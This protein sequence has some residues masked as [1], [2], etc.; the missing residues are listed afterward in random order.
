MPDLAWWL[1]NFKETAFRLETLPTY[2]SPREAE[3]LAAFRRGDAVRLPDDFPWLRM[4]KSHCS[5]GKTMQRVRLVQ[6][7]LSDYIRFEMS[8]YPQCVEA[9]EE[10]R[11]FEGNDSILGSPGD[12]WLFDQETCF[13]LH[14]DQHGA[15]IG[16]DTV[17]A[18]PYRQ[19]R[20]LAL[21][22]S[23]LLSDYTARAAR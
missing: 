8:L 3:M 13:V 4:V 9:G 23:T 10:I 20:R 11:I 5:S 2:D 17:E 21:Q 14:Y 22:W 19:S 7:P 16:T 1:E 18:T 15:F 6:Q 12:F